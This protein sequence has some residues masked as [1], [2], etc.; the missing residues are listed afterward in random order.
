MT[1]EQKMELIKGMTLEE[2]IEQLIRSAEFKGVANERYGRFDDRTREFA[3]EITLVKDELD[4]R[5]AMMAM[6]ENELEMQKP[7]TERE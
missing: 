1:R 3:E 2:L 7:A 5:M 4:A 6:A